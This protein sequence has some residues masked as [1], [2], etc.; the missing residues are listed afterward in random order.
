MKQNRDRQNWSQFSRRSFL[1][2]TGTVALA[3][4]LPIRPASAQTVAPYT[5]YNLSSAEG[6]QAL[7]SYQ[8]AITAMLAL[9]PSDPRNWYRNALIHLMDCPHGNWWFLPWHRGYLGWFEQICRQLSG[10]PDFALPYWDWTEEPY[11][12]SVFFEG[13][14][15]PTN[16]AFITSYNAFQAEFQNPISDFW[17]SLSPAQLEQLSQRGYNSLNDL[18]EDI[19]GSFVP[20]NQARNLT[21]QNPDFSF[22][23]RNAVSIN[24]VE[25]A[26]APSNFTDFGSGIAN[27]HSGGSVQGILEGQPH[28]SVHVNVG[29]FMG[30]FLSPV[31]PIFFMHHSNI[32]RLWDVWTRKQER[33]GLSPLPTPN[34]LAKWQSEPFLFFVD[35]NGNEVQANTAGDYA[36]IGSF[37]YVYQP[38]S[39]ESVISARRIARTFV[40]SLSSTVTD[41]ALNF[42]H[43]ATSNFDPS[44]LNLRSAVTEAESNTVVAE[45]TIQPPADPTGVTFNVLVNSPKQGHNIDFNSPHF[46][47]TFV[48]FGKPH[49]KGPVT[50]TVPLTSALKALKDKINLEQSLE[51]DVLP[52]TAG[53]TLDSL[54]TNLESVKIKVF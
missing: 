2:G 30:R 18:W 3:S 10:D 37:N 1:I 49:H 16:S 26:L 23:T 21:Q 31:D 22:T 43:L 12:P 51:I 25:D 46:A 54:E 11:I 19:A 8:A 27:Q 38:G 13:I 24:T 28:N 41:R 7:E 47:G 35:Q 39:G 17:S 29:G 14:F 45:I 34:D 52:D 50:F 44:V 53:I 15:N 5:R 36:T 4:T 40:R 20:S 42:S 9:P 33:L 48:F 32:E 6:E